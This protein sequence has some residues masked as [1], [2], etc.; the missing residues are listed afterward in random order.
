MA[1]RHSSRGVLPN[2]EF[3]CD[4][5][6]SV[7]RR[8]RSIRLSSHEKVCDKVSEYNRPTCPDIHLRCLTLPRM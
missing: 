4:L 7:M 6:T 5:E 3:K 8:P 2:V 1:V